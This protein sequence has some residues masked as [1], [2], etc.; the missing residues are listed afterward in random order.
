MYAPSMGRFMSRDTW[1]GDVNRPLSFNRW[2]YTYSNPVNYVDP[3]GNSPEV[4]SQILSQALFRYS[5]NLGQNVLEIV[6]STDCFGWIPFAHPTTT[7]VPLTTGDDWCRDGYCWNGTKMK[8]LFDTM[9]I[10]PGGGWWND[11]GRV[12]FEMETFLGL[13]LLKDMSS[14]ITVNNATSLLIEAAARQ[15]WSDA[16]PAGGEANYCTSG[17]NC[18]NAI[19][20]YLAKDIESAQRLYNAVILQGK[21]PDRPYQTDNQTD[22]ELLNEAASVGMQVLH[23]K[24]EWTILDM[25]AVYDWG[26]M[27]KYWKYSPTSVGDGAIHGVYL[28]QKGK[29]PSAQFY[30]Y[31]LNQSACLEGRTCSQ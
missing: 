23:P 17:Q 27:T 20:N 9:V 4:T 26:Q 10:W 30:M 2:N 5:K 11:Y 19:F 1:S 29:T 6:L 12:G 28:S 8:N 7:D 18:Y 3:S 21:N 13:M 31:S 16:R 22:G 15:I 14:A 25:N 24:P